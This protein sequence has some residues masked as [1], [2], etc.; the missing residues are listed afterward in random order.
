MSP[1]RNPY[2]FEPASDK[3]FVGRDE[4]L[5]HWRERLDPQSDSWKTA[6]SWIVYQAVTLGLPIIMLAGF[7]KG[8]IADPILGLGQAIIDPKKTWANL[9]A[10]KREHGW[11]A[12]SPIYQG[13]LH[14]NYKW[15]A[16]PIS[17]SACCY[18]NV[19]LGC[20][21]PAS[22]TYGQPRIKSV[23]R[24]R[25]RDRRRLKKAESGNEEHY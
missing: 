10:E 23:A 17:A 8:F 9:K 15:I 2:S 25:C 18:T 6:K 24:L 13:H 12:F 1:Q 14:T 3:E 20:Y 16:H 4:I 22:L 11:N 5:G 21:D 7:S 19:Q